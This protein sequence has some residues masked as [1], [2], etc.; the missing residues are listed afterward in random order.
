MVKAPYSYLAGK[1]SVVSKVLC[2]VPNGLPDRGISYKTRLYRSG[3]ATPMAVNRVE[4]YLTYL[5]TR[6]RW[7]G[8]RDQ[9]PD[10]PRRATWRPSTAGSSGSPSSHRR[11]YY[12]H[13][14]GATGPGPFAA[15]RPQTIPH[16]SRAVLYDSQ[17]GGSG[18]DAPPG[19]LPG[20]GRGPGWGCPAVPLRRSLAG[21][22]PPGLPDLRR[23]P[24]P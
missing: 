5:Q 24:G 12:S 4:E 14:L 22:H 15:G 9:H 11:T 20:R 21:N 19:A 16:S 17:S 18:K 10:R 6:P 3:A 7:F 13:R 23:H 8:E 1:A 2:I